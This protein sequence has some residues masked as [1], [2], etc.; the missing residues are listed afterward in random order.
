[1]AKLKKIIQLNKS[2]EGIADKATIG[3]TYEV[4]YNPVNQLVTPD[5]ETLSLFCYDRLQV[6]KDDVLIKS[7]LVRTF[8]RQD[9]K[10]TNWFSL[11]ES[12][13][14]KLHIENARIQDNKLHNI[15]N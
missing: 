2:V 15:Q 7:N 13:K 10:S 3:I 9:I 14:V 8:I 6:V 11:Y 1:M 12:S 4:H 5:W